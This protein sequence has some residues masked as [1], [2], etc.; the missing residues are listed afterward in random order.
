[1][2][3]RSGHPSGHRS[4]SPSSH[5]QRRAA[6]LDEDVGLSGRNRDVLHYEYGNLLFWLK[7]L[8]DRVQTRDDDDRGRLIGRLPSLAPG[9]PWTVRVE[10]AYSRL[11]NKI[12]P[13][14]PLANL[15]GHRGT[16]PHACAGQR[17]VDGRIE[18]P[19]PD[20][21]AGRVRETY[22]LSYEGDRGLQA[23][24][25]DALHH[26][27]AFVTETLA[28]LVEGDKEICR[29]RDANSGGD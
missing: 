20:P 17:I 16:V 3:T 6:F 15:L 5:S 2:K 8:K 24:A 1:M 27:D 21:P 7:G 26:V 22:K 10:A 4:S 28:A 12:H 29:R 19:I 23:F 13:E 9:E 14:R 11:Q 25:H 18:M